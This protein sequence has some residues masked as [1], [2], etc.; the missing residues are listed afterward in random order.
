MLANRIPIEYYTPVSY[1]QLSFKI[2]TYHYH[3]AFTFMYRSPDFLT[4]GVGKK[5]FPLKL[6]NSGHKIL[7]LRSW[8]MQMGIVY[9]GARSVYWLTLF[10]FYFFFL[11]CFS[12]IVLF[13]WLLSVK[14]LLRAGGGWEVRF[15][16]RA[17][18]YEMQH[19][20][21]LENT[22]QTWYWD[23][24]DWCLNHQISK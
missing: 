19:F 12:D 1:T 16:L 4:A 13:K 10:L 14:C 18:T 8:R 7:Q 2:V 9:V 21:A 11:F 15:V 20:T 22:L 5:A 6:F 3:F 24:M 17:E 23:Q